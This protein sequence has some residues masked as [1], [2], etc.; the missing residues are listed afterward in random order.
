MVAASGI[1]V[2]RKPAAQ[3][4]KDLCEVNVASR[5]L[6]YVIDSM[7]MGQTCGMKPKFVENGFQHPY[8]SRTC[9]RSGPG[10]KVPL[11]VVPSCR[12]APKAAHGRCCS[13]EHFRY[14]MVVLLSSPIAEHYRL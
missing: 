11:C 2:G 8:C 4:Q 10:S 7:L 9:A 3:T 12:Q 13:D 5:C 6:R 14:V 1:V